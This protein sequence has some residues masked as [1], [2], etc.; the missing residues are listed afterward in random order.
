MQPRA[1]INALR[2][3]TL[4]RR[5][6]QTAA[7]GLLWGLAT[8]GTVQAQHTDPAP[9]DPL[10][11][12]SPALLLLDVET[13]STHL[14]RC[15]KDPAYLARLGHLYNQ[16]QRYTEAANHLERALLLGPDNPHNQLDYAIALA[17]SGDAASA[18][19]LVLMLQQNPD[20]PTSLRTGLLNIGQV[21]ANANAN[22]GTTQ[23]FSAGV[24]WGYDNNLLGSPKLSTIALTL[25]TETITMQVDPTNRPRPGS[26]V[27]T[28]LHW[29]Q[30]RTQPDGSRWALEAGAL[31]RNSLSG[32]SAANS[33]QGELQLE[34]THPASYYAGATLT[35]LYS[36]ANTRYTS[37]GLVLGMERTPTTPAPHCTQRLGLEWQN[38]QLHSNTV[39]SGQYAGLS[40]QWG[41]NAPDSTQWQLIARAGQDQPQDGSRPGGAQA[42]YSLRARAS[43]STST[44]SLWLLDAETSYSR[45]ATG[46][47]PLLD[48][49]RRRNIQRLTLRLE[50]QYT[51]APGWRLLTGVE[52][53]TQNASLP[54][55]ALRSRSL[56]LGVRTHW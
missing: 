12:N 5:L 27:R 16:Q 15:Q 39:L 56:Y 38:R 3:H 48:N 23:R 36:H 4:A 33:T 42:Q 31:Q 1:L 51:L 25:P 9:A 2:G 35:T 54:L 49:N 22:N 30:V 11:C 52:T 40:A 26:F 28:D 50:H 45:D 32:L 20:L 41:C 18:L 46:Y 21:W 13:L 7:Q 53:L 37:Q 17:G 44:T 14:E 8:A 24:R 47:S 43:T 6:L 55:F 34:Y 10:D 19:N 29:H